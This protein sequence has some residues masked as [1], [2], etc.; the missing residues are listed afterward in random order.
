MSRFV[1]QPAR[2]LQTR[3]AASK[4]EP[5]EEVT[6]DELVKKLTPAKDPME[7][8]KLGRLK[9]GCFVGLVKSQ[10]TPNKLVIFVLHNLDNSG[11]IEFILKADPS[12]E[13]RLVCAYRVDVAEFD[14]R[15]TEVQSG[16]AA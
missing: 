4:T 6:F 13:G 8:I 5:A 11:D 9:P 16:E 15:V 7:G 3:F 1:L 12:F 14:A 10:R 2:I